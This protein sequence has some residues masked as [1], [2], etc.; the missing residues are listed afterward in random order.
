M[1]N[2][3]LADVSSTTEGRYS[4]E[5]EGGGSSWPI[6]G[7]LL[8]R[9]R[10]RRKKA[11]GYYR[12]TTVNWGYMEKRYLTIQIKGTRFST[13]PKR[14]SRE[15]GTELRLSPWFLGDYARSIGTRSLFFFFGKLFKHWFGKFCLR[16]ELRGFLNELFGCSIKKGW[17]EYTIEKDSNVSY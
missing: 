4:V 1:S 14:N 2:Y 9:G 13:R 10:E 16:S 7:R 8:R 11:Y 5:E 12:A 6:K 3:R 17:R 15:Y